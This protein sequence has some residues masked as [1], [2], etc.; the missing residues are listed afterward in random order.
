MQEM[1]TRDRVLFLRSWLASPRRTAAISPSGRSLAMLMTAQLG[2]ADAPVIELGPGTGVFTHALLE[3]GLIEGELT[4]V[5]YDPDFIPLLRARFP[6]TRIHHADA[7]RLHGLN[8]YPPAT[9]GAVISGLGL[10][11]MPQ[12]K[13]TAILIGAFSYL[14]PDGALYQFTYGPGCPVPSAILKRLGLRAQRIGG[15]LCNLPPASVYRITRADTAK[16]DDTGISR[17]SAGS[18]VPPLQA[19][20]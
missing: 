2:A 7:T 3:R 17:F 5:E 15:T 10:L 9:A 18:D 8:L 20:S 4:L 11:A 14:R 12:G 6:G 1:A 13:I 19:A 16:S